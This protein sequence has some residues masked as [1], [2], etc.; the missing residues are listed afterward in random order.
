MLLAAFI[1]DAIDRLARTSVDNPALDARLLI[2]HVL[3]L[4]RAALLAQ[5]AR[6]LTNDEEK[7]CHAL[8]DQRA[9]GKPVS[10]IV[11]KREFWRLPFGL[12]KATLDPRPDS[13]TMIEVLVSLWKTGW[14]KKEKNERILDLGTGTGCLLLSL[15]HERPNATGLGVDVT[16]DAVTQAKKNADA[17][18]FEKR[19]TFVQSDWFQNVTGTF[20]I[21]VSNPPYIET[22]TLQTLQREVRL[23][24]PTKALDGGDDGLTPYRLLIPQLARF[25]NLGGLAAF[26]IGQSQ[27]D[28]VAAMLQNNNFTTITK[29]KDLSGIVR[30]VMGRISF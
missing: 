8:L 17:L 26:E 5:S 30:V 6:A 29:H 1:K 28:A 27:A 13:E 23:F 22:N 21:I 12:N 4:D 25:L 10:R 11:G 3:G 15:L 18:D 16:D 2:G 19:A 20:D 7:A 14:G 9:A 24:D